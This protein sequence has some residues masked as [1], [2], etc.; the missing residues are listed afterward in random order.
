M[1]KPTGEDA[2]NGIK[3]HVEGFHHF[4]VAHQTRVIADGVMIGI[5]RAG[6]TTQE[7]S[8]KKT[9]EEGW[10][11]KKGDIVRVYNVNIVFQ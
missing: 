11:V 2:L 7:K 8:G 9:G 3:E 5:F 6:Q 1:T 4:E 10:T